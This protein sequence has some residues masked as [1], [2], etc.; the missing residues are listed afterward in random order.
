MP[1]LLAPGYKKPAWWRMLQ[2]DDDLTDPGSKGAEDFRRRLR[3]LFP[4][5]LNLVKDIEVANLRDF[6][7]DTTRALE[8]VPHMARNSLRDN[9]LIILI[10]P[11]C[12]RHVIFVSWLLHFSERRRH[13]E[14][15]TEK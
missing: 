10:R 6:A 3:I 8:T 4:I 15:K 5:F 2:R 7:P 9:N 1:Q 13:Y 12:D 11:S 14:G